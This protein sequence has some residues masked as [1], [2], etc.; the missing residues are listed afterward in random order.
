MAFGVGEQVAKKYFHR[1][2]FVVQHLDNLPAL[3]LAD[4]Q[5]NAESKYPAIVR[6]HTTDGRFFCSGFVISA[7]YVMTAAHCLT[8]DFELTDNPISIRLPSG[9]DVNTVGTPAAVNINS[10]L[11]L[12]TGDFS[13][14]NVVHV[15]TTPG[16][17]LQ[18]FMGAAGPVIS[19]GFPYGDQATCLQ[20]LP[21]TNFLNFIAGQGFLYPGM[22]GGPVFSLLTGIVVGV[23]SAMMEGGVLIAPIIGLF[24]EVGIIV[25]Y[26][27]LDQ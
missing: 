10:D 16:L 22:S 2:H 18:I 7:K 27:D 3:S 4:I 17:T 26:G 20:F 21:Q 5:A 13:G 1:Q 25:D 8:E 14:F 23:N 11:G 24:S 15:S 19:C 9:Q 6:L 12:I